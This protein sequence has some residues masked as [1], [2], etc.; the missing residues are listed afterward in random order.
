MFALITCESPFNIAVTPPDGGLF[1]PT[2]DLL[3]FPN[4]GEAYVILNWNLPGMDD[5]RSLEIWFQKIVPDTAESEDWQLAT[6]ITSSQASQYR[7][8]VYDDEDIIY[9]FTV[10]TKNGAIGY[11]ELI[12]PLPRTTRLTVPPGN[13]N[14]RQYYSSPLMDIGDTLFLAIGDH[15]EFELDASKKQISFIGVDLASKVNVLY[16]E[17]PLPPTKPMTYDFLLKVENCLLANITFTGVLY[18]GRNTQIENCLINGNLINWEESTYIDQD[19]FKT[20]VP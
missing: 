6:T 17:P 18:I 4:T 12:V 7:H 1:Q 8:T 15:Y 20:S 5:F 13:R 19:D 2:A 3:G 11:S 16:P 10:Q 14:L 9:R